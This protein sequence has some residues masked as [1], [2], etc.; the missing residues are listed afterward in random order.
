MFCDFCGSHTLVKVSVYINHNGEI[1]Y[2]KNPKRKAKLRGTKYSL[3]KPQGGR[4]GDGLI[5]REDELM[6]GEKRF[7]VKRI[8]KEKKI[9]MN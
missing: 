9:M 8:E 4:G 2:F 5:L 1:T 3:P 6:V 7:L